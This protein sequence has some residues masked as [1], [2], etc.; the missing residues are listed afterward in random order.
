MKHT[1]VRP[2]A[3]RLPVY[4]STS[5]EGQRLATEMQLRAAIRAHRRALH[6]AER[7]LLLV[8]KDTRASGAVEWSPLL[9]PTL[10]APVPAHVEVQSP[11][12]GPAGGAL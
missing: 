5:L 12:V 4:T 2:P 6:S 9:P 11:P 8:T 3:K 1:V 7:A 10:R